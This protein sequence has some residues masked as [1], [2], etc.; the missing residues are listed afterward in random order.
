VENL[1]VFDGSEFPTS[2]AANPMESIHSMV[3]KQA[4]ALAE[5]LTG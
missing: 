2:I 4:T 3:A 5:E 1:S